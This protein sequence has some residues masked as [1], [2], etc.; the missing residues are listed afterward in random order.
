MIDRRTV[1]KTITAIPILAVAGGIGAALLSFLKPTWAPLA[2]PATE[3]PL[4]DDLMAGTLA[5][6]PNEYDSKPITFTQTT[7]EYSAR[8]KQATDVLGFI[9]RVPVGRMDPAEVGVGPNGLRRGYGETE[10]GGQKYAIVA[11]SRICAHLGCIFEYHTTEEVCTGFN[12]CGGKNPMFSCPCHLSV[13]DPAQAQDVSG[14]QLAGRVV[15][16][17]APRT[18]FPFDFEFKDDQIIIKNYG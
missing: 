9:V 12:Y 18:P 6:F 4:N 1:L 3:K 2:F 8:G 14:A 17:P 13:Y 15:S 7:V 11:V 16:G 10:F 5:E